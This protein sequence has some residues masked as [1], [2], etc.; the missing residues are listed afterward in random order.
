MIPALDALRAR[1]G[2]RPRARAPR[3]AGCEGDRGRP[4][5]D[6]RD[7]AAH[8]AA[9]ARRR[10]LAPRAA[11]RR[12]A[13]R[14]AAHRSAHD[15]GGADRARR[16]RPPASQRSPSARA[17]IGD[18]QVRNLGTIGGS[19]AHADPASDMPAV[20]L[21]LGASLAGSIART[22][23]A[24]SSR[25]PTCSSGPSRRVWAAGARD[26]HRRSRFPRRAPAPR[27]RRSSIRHRASHLSAL[28]HSSALPARRSR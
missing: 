12:G 15:V 22:V 14:R 6:P 21:A 16:R 9:V 27:T 24:R 28:P 3:R 26:G 18:V 10:H 4:V 8:R 11:R 7:E 1:V 25:S 19:V 5:A 20:L 13:G 2:P 17:E 23:S